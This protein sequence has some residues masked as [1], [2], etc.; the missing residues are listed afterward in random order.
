MELIGVAA[1]FVV[2]ALLAAVPLVVLLHLVEWTSPRKAQ[3][4]R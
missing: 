2:L 1:L 3:R 4:D